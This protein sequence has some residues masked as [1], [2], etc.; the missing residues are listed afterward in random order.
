MRKFLGNDYLTPPV[1][2]VAGAAAAD[3][4]EPRASAEEPP[5]TTVTGR[6]MSRVLKSDRSSVPISDS[7]PAG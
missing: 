7:R 4:F 2:D 5:K 1:L 6:S 3:P